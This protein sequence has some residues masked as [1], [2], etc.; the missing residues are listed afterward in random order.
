MIAVAQTSAGSV[1][2]A[3]AVATGEI[4]AGLIQA[5]VAFRAV[6]GQGEFAAIAAARKLRALASLYAEK[7]H[8]VTRNDARI[9]SIADLRG[10]RFSIDEL[11]SGTLAVTR[12]VL[13]AYGL[14]ETDFVPV[15][16]KPVFTA[17]KMINGDLHGFAM[18]AG[19]PMEAVSRLADLDLFL[20]PVDPATAAGIN[21]RYPFLVPGKI[22]GGV[23]AGIPETPTLEVHAL[24]VVS[25][26]L[27]EETAYQVT[28]V[29]WGQRM[30]ALLDRGHASGKDI[31]R[32]SA[33]T[34]LS[35][36]LHSGA[37]RY[38]REQG[39]TIDPES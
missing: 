9:R 8:L 13:A 26:D 3:Q 35:L 25:E 39:I 12:I 32:E 17:E 5:D 22:P 15:Y 24:L 37:E 19:T 31:R 10:K 20:V 28:K 27:D 1:A 2:N 23:Y 7:L 38:Y 30:R 4:E 18:M 16:L 6:Q 21:A 36:P 29:L 33:L 34:G 14:S 11:G